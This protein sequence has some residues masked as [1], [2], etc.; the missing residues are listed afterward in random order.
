MTHLMM[1]LQDNDVDVIV[2]W[3][4]SSAGIDSFRGSKSLVGI[5][6]SFTACVYR[7]TLKGA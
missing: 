7:V 5:A 6:L 4:S 2:R 3:F 1:L